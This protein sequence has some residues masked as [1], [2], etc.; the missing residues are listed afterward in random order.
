[1]TYTPGQVCKLPVSFNIVF[2]IKGFMGLDMYLLC[3]SYDGN[4]FAYWRKANSIHNY[5]V[6]NVQNGNDDCGTYPVTKSDI[7]TLLDLCEE[8]L[9]NNRLA[10]KLLPT[11]GGFFFGSTL[12]DDDY[13]RDLRYTV[14]VCRRA[15]EYL[16]SGKELVYSS[17]W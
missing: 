11:V 13:Y 16:D 17:S 14:G 4:E 12:Y 9:D 15:L 7:S 6:E 5:F 8:V 2:K 10:S 1:L 3:D